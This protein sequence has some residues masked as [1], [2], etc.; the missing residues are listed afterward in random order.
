ML[1]A[2]APLL[3][4]LFLFCAKTCYY[5]GV[6]GARR[7]GGS[8][9]TRIITDQISDISRGMNVLWC[10][11][12]FISLSYNPPANGARSLSL[13]LCLG[14]VLGGGGG[15]GVSST[16][17]PLPLSLSIFLFLTRSLGAC[18]SWYAWLPQHKE[19]PQLRPGCVGEG[20]GNVECE[21]KKTWQ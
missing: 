5:A 15:N 19:A 20:E 10:V 12:Y 8:W 7:S 9:Q 13:S 6:A 21:I 16:P 4:A 17:T 14:L 2:L 1:P 3:L 18:V 11:F